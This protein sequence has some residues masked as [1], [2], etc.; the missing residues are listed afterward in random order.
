MREPGDV[1][2]TSLPVTAQ[3]EDDSEKRE[4]CEGALGESFS[5]YFTLGADP[6]IVDDPIEYTFF[7]LPEAFT[8]EVVTSGLHTQSSVSD[9]KA[10]M[11][12]QFFVIPPGISHEAKGRARL[13]V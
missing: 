4:T 9:L 8:W 13:V 7:Q 1:S 12:D 3:A 6:P 2:D 5:Q 11:F 10:S